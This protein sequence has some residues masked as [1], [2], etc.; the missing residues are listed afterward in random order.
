MPRAR[1]AELPPPKAFFVDREDVEVFRYPADMTGAGPKPAFDVLV[2][3]LPRM[4]ERGCYG[5]FRLREGPPEYFACAERL[6]S[7]PPKYAGLESGIIPGGLYV[8][9][10]F[11]GDWRQAIGDIP[12]HFERLVREYHNEPTRPSIEYYRGDNEL[13]LF[14]PVVDRKARSP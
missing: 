5:T 2:S 13:Q 3:T 6:P 7:D 1:T 8:R 14:L 10:I 4:P 11:F 9:R 12:G